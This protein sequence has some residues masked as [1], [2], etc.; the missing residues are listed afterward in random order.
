MDPQTKAFGI[1][2]FQVSM[3]YNTLREESK[4]CILLCANCHAEYEDG[5]W[6]LFEGLI[7]NKTAVFGDLAYSGL[8]YS[9][10]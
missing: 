5:L 9:L 3:S 8:N 7:N 2:K 1:A 6:T 10:S 4:K